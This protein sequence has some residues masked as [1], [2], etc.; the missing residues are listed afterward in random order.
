MDDPNAIV[1]A[2]DAAGYRLT[3][4][5]RV[6]AD[7]IT[8]HDGHFTA[9]ELESVANGR[10]LRLSRA[11]LFRALDLLT[12]LGALERI[13]LPDGDH[14]YVPCVRSHHHHVVCARCGRTTEVEGC[15]VPEAVAEIARRTGYRI[16]MHRLELFG[17]CGPCQLKPALNA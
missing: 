4:P 13:E 7:L 3:G 11:T 17:L 15:G 12:E 5:R 1:Q 10:G 16:D 6:V 14:A 2:L 9:S 8:R